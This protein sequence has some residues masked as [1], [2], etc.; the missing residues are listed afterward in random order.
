MSE[1]T[2]TISFYDDLLNSDLETLERKGLDTH[3][4]I[5]L[6]ILKNMRIS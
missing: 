4:N 3:Q 1:I 2:V 5:Y 6:A